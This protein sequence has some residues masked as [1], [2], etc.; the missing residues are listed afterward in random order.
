MTPGVGAILL[1]AM[2]HPWAVGPAEVSGQTQLDIAQ[3][4]LPRTAMICEAP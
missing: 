2:L 4:A 1:A 3:A